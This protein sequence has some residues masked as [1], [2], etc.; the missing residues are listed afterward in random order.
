MQG[1]FGAFG[2]SLK[3]QEPPPLLPWGQGEQ[4]KVL[5]KLSEPQ[6]R[7]EVE[8]WMRASSKGI[9]YLGGWWVWGSEWTPGRSCCG[10]HI[11]GSQDRCP[12]VWRSNNEAL[13]RTELFS[14][15]VCVASSR[16]PRASQSLWLISLLPLP[17]LLQVLL[18]IVPLLP[19]SRW[20]IIP[21]IRQEPMTSL[22]PICPRNTH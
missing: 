1:A 22:S 5:W 19:P 7:P 13:K 15:C 11:W 17:S 21:S 20:S 2:A 10:G 12:P 9:K 8:R 16:D 14:V 4:E 3:G 18:L 6:I